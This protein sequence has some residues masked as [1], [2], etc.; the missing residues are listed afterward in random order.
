MGA[1]RIFKKVGLF[2]TRRAARKVRRTRAS[3]GP[4]SGTVGRYLLREPLG[5][6]ACGEVWSAVDPH[7]ARIVAVKILNVPPGVE[8]RQ[9][10]EW[11][12]RFVREA[13]A[14]GM[15]SHPGIVTIHDVG[16]TRDGRPFIVMELVEGSS[17]DAVIR[18]GPAPSA[19]TALEWGAQVAEALDAAHR[20]GIV[21]RDVKPANVLID[22]E[23]RA[24]IADFGIARLSESDLTHRGLFLGSPAFA[25]PEQIKGAALDGRSDLFSLGAALYTLLT[26][27]RPFTGEDLTSVAYAICHTEPEPPR[28]LAPHLAPECEAVVMRALAKDPGRRHPGGQHLA[29]DLRAAAAAQAQADAAARP[30][31]KRAGGKQHR[32]SAPR[33]ERAGSRA[34]SGGSPGRPRAARPAP[35]PSAPHAGAML[36]AVVMVLGVATAGGYL[37]T[38]SGAAPSRAPAASGARAGVSPPRADAKPDRRAAEGGTPRGA[39]REGAATSRSAE[40]LPWAGGDGGADATVVSVQVLHSLPDGVAT[41]WSGPRRLLHVRLEAPGP[42]AGASGQE[43]LVRES[44][45]PM[46]PVRLPAGEHRLRVEVVS[47]RMRLDLKQEI[48]RTV[49]ARQRF[50]LHVRV[51]TR[52]KPELELLWSDD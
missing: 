42:G 25:S 41:V 7:I 6:G 2:G 20:R 48:S 9:K 16:T 47:R 44:T 22:T 14:A 37:L 33:A 19:A 4:S 43:A 3:P 28:R 21:H 23:G 30:R 38:W 49:L 17:L 27:E 32:A 45:S 18:D 35:R 5:R 50:R 34:E 8:G 1:G 51:R 39:R 13:R 52:P 15:L 29:A 24:R 36:L 31:S 46:W 11:E 12:Q 40:S 10:L 26:G